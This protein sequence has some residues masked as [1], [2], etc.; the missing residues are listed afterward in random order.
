ML[1]RQDIVDEA[2]SWLGVK[3][4]HQG[5]TRYGIDCAGLVIEVAKSLGL[6]AYDTTN[7]QRRT[8]GHKFLNHFRQ[9]MIEKRISDALPGDVMLFRDDMYPCHSTILGD[10]SA[11]LTIIH[12]HATRRAV[13][14]DFLHQGD[15][16]DR[17]V[18]C[19]E[20]EGVR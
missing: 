6:S 12:A 1:N 5:R 11:M 19:F 8:H 2:R 20:F 16:Q 17:C 7:Y 9:N 15:W 18:A 10:R 4:V 14:E 13:V 3:W